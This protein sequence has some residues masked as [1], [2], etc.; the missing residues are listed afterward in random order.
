MKFAADENFNNDILRALKRQA[1]ALDIV[2]IQDT[3]IYQADDPAV[4]AW[5]AEK[6]RILLTHDVKTIPK[7]AYERVTANQ[8]M[9]DVFVVSDTMSVGAAAEQQLITVSASE[10]SEWENIVMFFPL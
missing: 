7:Y 3:A 4:L 10:S 5:A 9:P 1:V 6:E 8:K 2:R